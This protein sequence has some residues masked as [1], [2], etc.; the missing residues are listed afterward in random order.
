MA[1]W[2]VKALALS[3]AVVTSTFLTTLVGAAMPPL[4]GSVLF[5]GGL[6]AGLLLL[7]GVGEQAAA[8]VLLWSRPE[9][10]SWRCWP[11]R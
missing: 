11:A 5:F 7:V 2:L 6:L 1:R 8:R 3:P 4:A 10:R 9:M